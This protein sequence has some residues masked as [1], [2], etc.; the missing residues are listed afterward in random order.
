MNYTNY[1]RK[2][3]SDTRFRNKLLNKSMTKNFSTC[4]CKIC[5]VSP[6]PPHMSN[7]SDSPESPDALELSYAPEVLIGYE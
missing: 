2:F 3:T 7:S 6:E 4:K 5:K 1:P